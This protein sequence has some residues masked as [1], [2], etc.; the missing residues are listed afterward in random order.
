VPHFTCV[1]GGDISLS[2][3]PNGHEFPVFSDGQL[4]ELEENLGSQL[5]GELTQRKVSEIFTSRRPKAELIEC[6]ACGRLAL[7]R[8]M[9]DRAPI[10]WYAP[11]IP[12]GTTVSKLRDLFLPYLGDGG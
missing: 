6:P 11:E 4:L 2:S 10:T 5:S 3:F 9:G 1:C 12:V 7:F 8:D